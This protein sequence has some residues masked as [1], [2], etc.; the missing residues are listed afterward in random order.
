M[1]AIP[2]LLVLAT[3]IALVYLPRIRKPAL[4][5]GV[6]LFALA[7]LGGG[8]VWI[9]S[10]VEDRKAS[11]EHD[12]ELSLMV[13]H[14]IGKPPHCKS[15]PF[16]ARYD[17]LLGDPLKRAQKRATNTLP[18]TDLDRAV[19]AGARPVVGDFIPDG[20]T[21]HQPEGD[22]APDLGSVIVAPDGSKTIAGAAGGDFIP[23]G[24]TKHQLERKH[25][26]RKP[27]G[28][29]AV[30]PEGA[31]GGDP[32]AAYVKPE[33]S[34]NAQFDPDAYLCTQEVAELG[35]FI[36]ERGFELNGFI[37]DH[38]HDSRVDAL[39]TAL[40]E[41]GIDFQKTC[42]NLVDEKL[43]EYELHQHGCK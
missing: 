23:D 4:W 24:T 34:Q 36:K 12:Y 29:W 13:D 28:D 10:R 9:Y 21:K 37:Q 5:L 1:Y 20:T 7:A 43:D 22:L 40:E 18:T 26:A 30:V 6:S 27:K 35:S 2:A 3:L 32:F 11:R 17:T 19:A 33:A 38:Q 42:K 31:V 8:G 16:T 41:N 25:G 39:Q 14:A 15:K